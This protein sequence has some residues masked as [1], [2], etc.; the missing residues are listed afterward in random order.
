MRLTVASD[1]SVASPPFVGADGETPAD[2]ASTP[3]CTVTRDDG[4]VLAAPTVSG[5]TAGDGVYQA[6][7]T[8][9]V[10]TSRV[11]RLTLIWTGTVTGAGQQRHTQIVDVAGGVYATL[12]ELRDLDD[13]DDTIT[14]PTA[15][16]RQLREE[17]EDR[18]EAWLDEAQVNRYASEK[19]RGWGGST[20]MLSHRNPREI[21]SA[22]DVA[23]DGSL[24]A[25]SN[26][27]QWT[28]DR[29]GQVTATTTFTRPADRRANVIVRY[30][31][32]ADN[33]DP[34]L[35]EAC[36]LFV[37]AK[38]L[39]RAGNRFGRDVISQSQEGVTIRYSTPD[40]RNGRPTGI[41][42]VDAILTGMAPGVVRV[43]FG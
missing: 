42:D 32:G 23:A 8:A 27:N 34:D 10:H 30:R 9:A 1:A 22:S 15:L 36:R 2:T 20:L 37:R 40:P 21:I 7:L 19:L 24:S 3:T 5:G 17:F 43:G 33:P 26:V 39:E 18:A 25:Y 35:V 31:H 13:L 12:A 6:A 16:L 4:T 29:T 14:F 11:D 38:A 41:L 28:F